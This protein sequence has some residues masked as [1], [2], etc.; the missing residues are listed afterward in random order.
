MG[1][2][3][4]HRQDCISY[5]CFDVLKMLERQIK[6]GEEMTSNGQCSF[7]LS[8]QG[9]L[10]GGHIQAETSMQI[11]PGRTFLIEQEPETLRLG[12]VIGSLPPWAPS[13]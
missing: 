12:V 10:L 4:T 2:I 13:E 5:P 3:Q 6:Q 1:S 8:R 9:S 7:G 11:S